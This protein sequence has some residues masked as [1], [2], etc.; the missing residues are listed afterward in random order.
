METRRSFL[1]KIAYTAPVIMTLA[2]RPT[3][4]AAT[5]GGGGSGTK[6]HSDGPGPRAAASGGDGHA[7][8]AVWRNW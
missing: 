8:W 7:W 4:A 3:Y 1:K 5:Y 6:P 2:V